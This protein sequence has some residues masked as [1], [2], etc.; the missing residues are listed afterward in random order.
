MKNIIIFLFLALFT[1]T[2]CN[3]KKTLV[4]EETTDLIIENDIDSFTSIIDLVQLETTIDI[5]ETK[6]DSSEVV[7]TVTEYSEPDSSGNQSIV[8]T[9]SRVTKNNIKT[10]KAIVAEIIDS[11]RRE[12]NNRYIDKSNIEFSLKTKT[13][14]KIKEKSKMPIIIFW[15]VLVVAIFVMLYF[16]WKKWFPFA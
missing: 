9:I 10:D 13:T 11:S 5:H 1:L 3:T 6:T 16:A 2:A 8:R 12:Q 15:I 4:T 7:T 14:S